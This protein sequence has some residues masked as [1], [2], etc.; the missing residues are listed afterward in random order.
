MNRPREMRE[1]VSLLKTGYCRE[2]K[3]IVMR[4]PAS[5]QQGEGTIVDLIR[6]LARWTIQIRVSGH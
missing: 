1:P 4:E 2:R 5:S 3:I 6:E